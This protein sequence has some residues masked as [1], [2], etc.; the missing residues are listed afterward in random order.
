MAVHRHIVRATR[1]PGVVVVGVIIPAEAAA[2]RA[3]RI[4]PP[5]LRASLT[6]SPAQPRPPVAEPSVGPVGCVGLRCHLPEWVD[7]IAIAMT[8][9]A[10][11]QQARLHDQQHHPGRCW[12]QGA[13][14][15]NRGVVAN[16]RLLVVR[17]LLS[18]EV[19]PFSERSNASARAATSGSG[20]RSAMRSVVASSREYFSPMT[21]E[22]Q[23]SRSRTTRNIFSSCV[24]VTNG[25]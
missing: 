21:T 9:A 5:G 1:R 19:Y 4:P 14:R 13:D 11:G 3:P 16:S 6:R 17:S 10:Q 20:I 18:C 12:G 24:A 15:W 7:S 23:R 2:R 8:S 22:N 25:R